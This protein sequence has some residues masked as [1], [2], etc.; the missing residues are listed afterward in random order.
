M[1]VHLKFWKAQLLRGA[2]LE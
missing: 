2:G 1:F